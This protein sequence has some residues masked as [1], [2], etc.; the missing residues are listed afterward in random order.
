MSDASGAGELFYA[1][2]IR[3]IYIHMIWMGLAGCLL[4]GWRYGWTVGLGFLVGAA[5]SVINFRWLHRLADSL[6]PAAS[7]PPRKG[8]K[9]LL[10]LRYVIFGV[11]GY[12][13]V[14]YFRVNMLAALVGL[15]VAVAAVLV[16]ILYELIYART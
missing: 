14:R 3:R 9:L 1:R 12:V 5:V 10:P 6:D 13:I 15:F 2:A 16:E 8:L 4:A 11:A 7:R